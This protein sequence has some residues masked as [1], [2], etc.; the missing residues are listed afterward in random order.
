MARTFSGSVM[1]PIGLV[2]KLDCLGQRILGKVDDESFTLTFPRSG[3]DVG[4][5]Q[6]PEFHES[7]W[8]NDDDDNPRF[9]GLS[10]PEVGAAFV[11]GMA[12]WVNTTTVPDKTSADVTAAYAQEMFP[13]VFARWMGR[14]STLLELWA[15]QGVQRF[16]GSKSE[17]SVVQLFDHNTDTPYTAEAAE[18][19]IA[20]IAAK[21]GFRYLSLADFRLAAKLVSDGDP[22][23]VAWQIFNRAQKLVRTEPR[24]AVIEA[25]TAVEVAVGRRVADSLFGYPAEA[26][27]QILTNAGGLVGLIKLQDK[28]YPRD[29]NRKRPNFSN[30]LAELRNKVAHAGKLPN[31]EEVIAALNAA[32]L[33]LDEVCPLPA[34][35]S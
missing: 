11:T 1:L 29:K 13:T 33:L 8:L 15:G 24:F 35:D 19:A 3:S 6:P 27:E 34:P 25:C 4:N 26:R 32:R 21:V 14:V 5:L 2:V 17:G 28:L 23:D 7:Q 20:G 12:I 9:W 18:N 22:L 30:S 10:N 31:T 16:L